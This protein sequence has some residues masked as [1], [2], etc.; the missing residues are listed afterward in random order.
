L[1]D[2]S[3]AGD[4][5]R[6]TEEGALPFDLETAPEAAICAFLRFFALFAAAESNNNSKEGVG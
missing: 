4:G 6:G 5:S 1:H 3:G 2:R